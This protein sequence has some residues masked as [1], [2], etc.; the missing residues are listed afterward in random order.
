VIGRRTH[1]VSAH[2]APECVL[3]FTCGND[4]TARDV[5][6]TDGQ[7]TRAKSFDTF[8]PLGP[9]V[10]RDAPPSEAAVTAAVDGGEVQR[11]RVGDMIVSPLDLLVFVSGVMTLEAGDVILTGTPPGVGPLAPGQVV[12][13]TVEG[14]GRLSNPVVAG[15]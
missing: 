11:G 8:C 6:K 13:I 9:A 15:A 12:T 4:V 1:R 5:Q 14:V 7:W 3:G 10:V 2:I